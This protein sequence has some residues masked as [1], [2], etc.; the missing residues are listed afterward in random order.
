MRRRIPAAGLAAALAAAFAFFPLAE[1]HAAD[2]ALLTY[3]S[4]GVAEGLANDSVYCI[5]QDSSGFMWFGTFGGLSRYDGESITTYRPHEGAGALQ[6]SLV[7]ALAE[8]GRGRLW[9][10]TDG[11]G[12]ACYDRATDSFAVRRA[13]PADPSA[14]SSDRVLALGRDSKGRLWAGMGD[15]MLNVLDP[16]T[17]GISRIL[18]PDG[19]PRHPIRCVAADASGG[20]WAGTEGGGLVYVGAD[21]RVRAYRH[22]ASD[23]SS[24]ASDVVRSLLVD[25]AGRVWVGLGNGGIDLFAGGHFRHARAAPGATLP[26][27]AVRALVEDSDGDVWVGWADSGIGFLDPA[28]MTIHPPEAGDPAMIRALYRDRGGLVWAGMKGGGTRTFNVASGHFQRFVQLVD[29]GEIRQ[30][31]GM[32]EL[33]DGRVLAGT[34]GEGLLVLDAASGKA[35]RYPGMPRDRVFL[36]IYAVIV[37]RDGSIWAGTDGGGLIHRTSDGMVAIYRNRGDDADS[38]SSDVVWCLLEDPDGRLWVGTEGGGLDRLDPATGR[39]E[40]FRHGAGLPGSLQGSSIR[41]LYRD[42]TGRLWIATW[43][44]GLSRLDPGSGNF[45][46]YQ[47]ETGKDRSLPDASVN[48]VLEDGLGN[49]WV[50]TGGSGLACLDAGSGTFR[51]YDVAS[52]L[53]G[54]TVY[55]L[56]DD[57][58]GLIWITTATGLSSLDRSTGSFFSY[59]AEDGLTPGGLSQNASLEARDGAIW[60]GGPEGITRFFPAEAARTTPTPAVAI[61]S[62][63]G[64]DGSLPRRSADG[65]KVFLPYGNAGLGF[66]IA[67]LDYSAPSRNRYALKLEG[68]QAG[69]TE[70]GYS[71]AGAL[72][73]LAP[74]EYLLRVKGANGNGVWNEEGVSLAIVVEPPVWGRPW[75]RVFIAAILAAI[76][77]LVIALRTRSLRTRNE[78]LVNFA[79]HVENAREE[80][81]TNA[82]REVHDEI[83]QHLA[84]LNLQS[85]WMRNHPDAPTSERASRL[86]VMQATISEALNAVKAVATRLRPI[87]LDA[88]TFGET[89]S[90]Y[91]RDFERRTGVACRATIGKDIPPLTDAEATALFRVLQEALANVA[92]HSGA[93]NVYIGLSSDEAWVVLV[94]EDDGKGMEAGEAEAPDAF[95]IIGMRERCA[96]FG[97]S[98]EVRSAPG[99]GTAVVARVP[100]KG[101]E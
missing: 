24:L 7:F 13:Q 40:H 33:P 50:G 43:D 36:K 68:R 83:G 58:N 70:L 38:I 16:A 35:S 39:F 32:A 72:A 85:Y 20:V 101:R 41:S 26:D 73:Q 14:P 22:M 77:A 98:L 55:G 64:L 95:G 54:S 19:G 80:E 62:V 23:A 44:G 65:T 91:A 53:V 56:L 37:G 100:A 52:G 76:V 49:I 90:W 27:E 60:V 5:F 12:L 59:G 66:R 69:W 88:L 47:P 17:D 2:P 10:G 15:G 92:R 61:T 6:A 11:G 3:H 8:D 84:V 4:L 1:A 63:V 86:E 30:A 71:N 48:C 42:M 34:D 18:P 99:Q 75:F 28:K 93:H 79:H 21:G 74:G 51:R 67:V 9:I 57:R 81:R 45:F 46:N 89:A 82:A 87:A 31:R 97:G 29:G 25:G 94:V 78:L 96:G